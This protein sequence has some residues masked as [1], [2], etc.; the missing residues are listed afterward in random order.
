MAAPFPLVAVE[1]ERVFAQACRV[2]HELLALVEQ[3]ARHPNTALAEEVRHPSK[4]RVVAHHPS[5]A[6]A[7]VDLHPN[8]VLAEQVALHQS[9]VLGEVQ[10]VA[11]AQEVPVGH[12]QAVE[13]L[14][15][16][17]LVHTLAEVGQ[18][19]LAWMVP[20]EGVLPLVGD[21]E[22]PAWMVRVVLAAHKQQEVLVLPLAGDQEA[23]DLHAVGAQDHDLALDRRLG[24]LLLVRRLD[25]AQSS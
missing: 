13:D 11:V 16:E 15:E 5:M 24:E 1:E 3:V 6:L 25:L 14:V 8:M 2:V 10:I 20:V 18:E 9:K 7:E 19:D 23:L 22:V 21:P 4:E 12:M 17:A